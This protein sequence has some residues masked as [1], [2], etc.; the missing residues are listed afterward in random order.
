MFFRNGVCMYVCMYVCSSAVVVADF[1]VQ[2][3]DRLVMAGN[4]G[5]L[6]CVVPSYL[7]EFVTVTSWL[8]GDHLHV[9]PSLHGGEYLAGTYLRFEFHL[10]YYVI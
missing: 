9:Y 10:Y 1:E 5:V 4:T 7:R 3:Y 2:V 6:H 8:I